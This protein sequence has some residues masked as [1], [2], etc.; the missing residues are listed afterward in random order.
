MSE[1]RGVRIS[2]KE[3][4]IK[5]GLLDLLQPGDMIMA[6][7]GFDTQEVVAKKG[8]LINV[9]PKLESKSKQMPAL[10]VEE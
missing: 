6:D 1:A 7:K 5:S 3:I 8:T 9:R 4:T 10:D 2:G